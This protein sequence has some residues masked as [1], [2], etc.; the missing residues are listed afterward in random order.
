MTATINASLNLQTSIEVNENLCFN[1]KLFEAC[2]KGPHISNILGD[3]G[4]SIT[5]HPVLIDIRQIHDL[6]YIAHKYNSELDR[7][8]GFQTRADQDLDQDIVD[9]IAKDMNNRKWDPFLMQGA[10]FPLPEEFRGMSFDTDGTERIYGIANLTHRLYAA[11]KSGQTH[12]IAWIVDISLSKLRKWANA[13]ANR[14][15]YA[16]NPRNDLIDITESIL[17]DKADESSELSIAL[18]NAATPE[19]QEEVIKNEVES[20]NVHSK[21]RD[22]IVRRLAMKGGFTPERKKW[23]ADFMREYVEDTFQEWVKSGDKLYDYISENDVPVILAQDEGRGY[24][25]VAEKWAQH[26]LAK[27][28][29]GPL[30]VLQALKKTG[31]IDKMKADQVRREFSKKVGEHLKMMGEAY[32]KIYVEDTGTLPRYE[33]FPEFA[34]ETSMIKLY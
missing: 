30:R 2:K 4:K 25:E 22:A 32:H 21:T 23:D 15:Q 7:P 27:D 20:Y 33:A 11:R 19:K 17:E 29:N 31:K 9:D 6:G 24:A 13:E 16:S 28:G 12:I 5:P 1:T 34:G 14:K 10:V 26:V 18:N 8:R 3:Y